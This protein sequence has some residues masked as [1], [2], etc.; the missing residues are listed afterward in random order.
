MAARRRTTALIRH[1]CSDQ[2]SM[3]PSS[4]RFAAEGIAAEGIAAEGIAA[5]GIATEGIAAERIAA[6]EIATKRQPR[7][8]RKHPGTTVGIPS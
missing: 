7:N 3:A 5:E 8:P 2:C 1:R 6:E 4:V